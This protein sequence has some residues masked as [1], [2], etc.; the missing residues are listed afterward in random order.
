M[1]K[2]EEN[3]YPHFCIQKMKFFC[4]TMLCIHEPLKQNN[5][6]KIMILVNK[7]EMNCPN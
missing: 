2:N 5:L 6:N 3:H 1:H 4:T 7:T